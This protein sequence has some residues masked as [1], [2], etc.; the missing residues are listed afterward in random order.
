MVAATVLIPTHDHQDTLLLA[1]ASAQAQSVRDIEIVIAGDGVPE[2]TREIVRTLQAGDPRIRFLD[3]P[4]GPRHGEINRHAA[5]LTAAGLRIA[6]LS[7]DDLWLP[8]HLA[9]LLAALDDADLAHT[10]HVEV[11]PDG[12]VQATPFDLADPRTRE[13]MLARDMDNFGLSVAGHSAAAYRRL[14]EGWRTTPAGKAVTLAMWK[15]WL[16]EPWCRAVSVL[17]PTALHFPS[18]SRRGW[19]V[20]QRVAEM[21]GWAARTREPDFVGWLQERIIAALS[22][23]YSDQVFQ[24]DALYRE[25]VALRDS[26][27]RRWLAWI[28]PLRR[29]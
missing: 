26:R 8:H 12:R 7:D 23:A 4:K 13:H 11:T 5:V 22:A 1:V 25:Y 9:T 24:G 15:Q 16:G 27:A 19:T 2:R 29:G 20:A 6:Y 17:R 21:T 3:N 14:P 18:V 28:S 10:M